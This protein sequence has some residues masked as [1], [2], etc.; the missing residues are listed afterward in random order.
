M[1]N[2]CLWPF[3]KVVMETVVVDC[4]CMQSNIVEGMGIMQIQSKSGLLRE[5]IFTDC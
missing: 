1:C 5:E 2:N 4:M 3:D